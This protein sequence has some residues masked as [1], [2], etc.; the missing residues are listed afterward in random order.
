MS[1]VSSQH[2]QPL[3][4]GQQLTPPARNQAVGDERNGDGERNLDNDET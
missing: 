1:G 4:H 3:G 2:L